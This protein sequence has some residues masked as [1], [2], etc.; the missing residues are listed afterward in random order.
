MTIAQRDWQCPLPMLLAPSPSPY[1]FPLAPAR[2][3]R[4]HKRPVDLK[5]AG[6]LGLL[7]GANGLCEIAAGFSL[8][9]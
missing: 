3:G 6:L 1:P 2:R 4:A 9:C 8:G 7:F 5:N